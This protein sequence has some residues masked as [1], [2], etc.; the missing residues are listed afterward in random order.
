MRARRRVRRKSRPPTERWTGS[1]TSSW[2]PA[3]GRSSTARPRPLRRQ[4]NRRHP[5]SAGVH[6]RPRQQRCSDE[7]RRSVRRPARRVLGAPGRDSMSRMAYRDPNDLLAYRRAHRAEA[8]ERARLWRLA[9]PGAAKAWRAAN[10]ER[11]AEHARRWRA[12]NRERVRERQRAWRQKTGYAKSLRRKADNFKAGLKN[13]GLT[14][15]EYDALLAEQGGACAI[16]RASTPRMRNATRLYV[17]H[18]HET[19]QIRGLLC[20]RCNTMI[21]LADDSTDRLRAAIH[22]LNATHGRGPV[23]SEK[24]RLLGSRRVRSMGRSPRRKA[25]RGAVASS[26][27]PPVRAVGAI[28][29]RRANCARAPAQR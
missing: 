1:S 28:L 4:S 20:F 7:D 29:V 15:A 2:T 10:P 12:A 14:P 19:D 16:C 13:H 11:A 9:H 23:R 24:R 21:A 27:T 3:S 5:R 26:G 8:N 22:Y 18:C 25:V 17:D 6:R